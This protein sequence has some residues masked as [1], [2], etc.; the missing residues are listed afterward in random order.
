MNQPNT[1]GM[2]LVFICHCWRPTWVEEVVV[3]GD[4]LKQR[5]AIAVHRHDT[6]VGADGLHVSNESCQMTYDDQRPLA[7]LQ[8]LGAL[9][10]QPMV[11]W[12]Q[13]RG[14]LYC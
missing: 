14:L 6:S 2:A 3:K 8:E 11:C 10:A 7:C 12:L 1:D 4:S 5:L 9:Q 13:Q